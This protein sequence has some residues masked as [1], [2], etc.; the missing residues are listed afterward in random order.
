[1]KFNFF[2]AILINTMIF[3]INVMDL[4]NSLKSFLNSSFLLA[5]VGAGIFLVYDWQKGDEVTKAARL[6][7]IE[8]RASETVITSLRDNN[9]NVSLLTKSVLTQNSWKK[10]NHLF[11]KKL[12]MDELN[13][14]TRFYNL[15]ELSQKQLDFLYESQ[16]AQVNEKLM[17][18][19]RK[20]VEMAANKTITKEEFEATKKH[21][22]ELIGPDNSISTPNDPKKKLSQLFDNIT[23]LGSITNSSAFE[24]IK[25]IAGIKD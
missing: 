13:L 6:L 24:E 3:T 20:I 18:I 25:K 10:Y 22:L 4:I 11:T 12:N 15:A 8:I 9:L 23:A 19:Q 14:I 16:V 1:L 21:F 5:L 7:I 2:C 17:S